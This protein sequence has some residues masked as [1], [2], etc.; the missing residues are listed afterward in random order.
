MQRKIN[1]SER[2]DSELA[3]L[4][5]N[6]RFAGLLKQV[7]KT[8]ALLE[9]NLKHPGLHTHKFSTME[10]ANGEEVFEAYVQNNTPG[11]CRV[12]WHY[13]PDEIAGKKRIPVISILAITSHP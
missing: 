6:P 2:A 8:L 12:F 7:V 3:A 13:G 5:K 11:A 10:G 4:E 1:L 9:T